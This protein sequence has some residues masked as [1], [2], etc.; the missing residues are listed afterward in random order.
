[1][2]L[3]NRTCVYSMLRFY[4]CYWRSL[5]GAESTQLRCQ[6]EAT[7]DVEIKCGFFWIDNWLSY[8][9][10]FKPYVIRYTTNKKSDLVP[11]YFVGKGDNGATKVKY[12]ANKVCILAKKRDNSLPSGKSV[13]LCNSQT[14]FYEKG[15][16]D[17]IS[18][19]TCSLTL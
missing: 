5:Y 7:N 14:E 13:P 18:G 17:I 3:Y 6:N 11:Y 12:G 9:P 16:Y 15:Y 1:M 8:F 10:L 2:D 19:Y 4:L